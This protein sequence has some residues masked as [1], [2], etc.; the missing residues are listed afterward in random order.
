MPLNE[1]FKKDVGAWNCPNC[2][3]NNKAHQSM[4]PC[5]STQ[6]PFSSSSTSKPADK[7][8]ISS[9]NVPLKELFKT[10][11]GSWSCP[12]CYVTNKVDQLTCPC[13]A[14]AKPQS[15]DVSIITSKSLS[16]TTSDNSS[17]MSLFKKD[18]GSWSCPTCMVMNKPD[19]ALCPCCNTKKPAMS[20][21]IK[22]ATS[23]DSTSLM[24]L[25]K[26]DAD[27]WNCP[28]C[29][30]TNKPS[31]LV[32]P[33]CNTKK[34]ELSTTVTTLASSDSS[35]LMGLFKQ[36]AGSW[37]CPTCMV[38]NKPDQVVCP[39]CNTKKPE[40]SSSVKTDCS[41]TTTTSS[42]LMD[43]F[44][45]DAGSWNCPTCMVS[46]KA[47]QL[48]CPCCATPMPQKPGKDTIATDK[49]SG[50]PAN[51]STL[52]TSSSSVTISSNKTTVLSHSATLKE[53]VTVTS[54]ISSAPLLSDVFKKKANTWDCPT[55]FVTNKVEQKMCPCCN[56]SQPAS[57]STSLA[58]ASSYTSSSKSKMTS[59]DIFKENDKSVQK[60][61]LNSSDSKVIAKCIV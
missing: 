39:C 17:L 25:F 26:Q 21:S 5:C 40:L 16:G 13:C 57:Q 11:A 29:M 15:S 35:S 61:D 50:L 30:V 34:P 55:C 38:A 27:S 32:C 51:S 28:T 1:L 60:A 42:S 24:N 54:S 19:Q 6:K 48:M 3:V 33:C 2:F 9:S 41:K 31:Q 8:S 49:S 45:Q 18:V 22:T 7:N 10:D 56:T 58:A 44:K 46:N 20:N 52:S 37:S 36:E 59:I 12:S 14:T 53:P 43:L 23:S 47:S 4:C